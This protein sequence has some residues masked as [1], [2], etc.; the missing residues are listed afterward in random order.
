MPRLESS[1]SSSVIEVQLL[2]GFTVAIDGAAMPAEAWRLKHPRSLFQMLCLKP[3]HQLHR[4]E[5]AGA[6]WPGADAKAAHNRLYHTVHVLRTEFAR[7]GLADSEPVLNF[8][9]GTLQLNPRH[10]FEIDRLAFGKALDRC[11]QVGESVDLASLEAA[12]AFFAGGHAA[13]VEDGSEW[14]TSLH[15][16]LRTGRVWLLERMADRLRDANRSDDAVLA[17]QQLVAIEPANEPAHRALM[18]LF[19]AAGQP[20]KAMLQ[21]ASCKRHLRRELAALPAAETESLREAVVARARGLRTKIA[22]GGTP[23]NSLGRVAL[24]DP[25]IGREAE[26]AELLAW[27]AHV[28]TR[29]VT[30]AAPPGTGKTRLAQA[31]AQRL[32]P[33]RRDGALWVALSELKDANGL[34]ALLCKALGVSAGA[35]AHGAVLRAFLADKELILVLDRFEHLV[36]AAPR[37]SNLIESAPGLQVLVASQRVLRCRFERVFD[38]RQLGR[39]SPTAA[40]ELLQRRA[41]AV[42]M[43]IESAADRDLAAQLCRRLDGNALAIELAAAQLRNG[44]LEELARG[45]GFPL[46][47]AKADSAEPQTRSLRHAIDWSVSRLDAKALDLLVTLGVFERAFDLDDLL[48]VAGA[49]SGDI[50]AR[51]SLQTLL[52]SGL[53]CREARSQGDT[54]A[55]RF[56]MLEFVRRFVREPAHDRPQRAVIE[57]AHAHWFRRRAHEAD[58]LERTGHGVAAYSIFERIEPDL[59]RALDWWAASGDSE[60]YLQTCADA[61]LLQFSH[62]RFEP[63]I[64]RLRSAVDVVAN[65]AAASRHSA[66]CA[67]TLS[68]ALQV[69]N[70]LPGA[71]RAI[72]LAR[73]RACAAAD[74]FLDEKVATQLTALRWM[75]LNPRAAALHIDALMRRFERKYAPSGSPSLFAVA[76]SVR[77]LQGNYA[78]A[79]KFAEASLDAALDRNNLG[80]VRLAQQTLLGA[81]LRK[82]H[83][84]RA[85]EHARECRAI[86]IVGPSGASLMYRQF[87]YFHLHFESAEYEAARESLLHLRHLPVASQ[88]P[89]AREIDIALDFILIETGR[90]GEA[91]NL[92]APVTLTNGHFNPLY[93]QLHAYRLPIQARSGATPEA[94]DSLAAALRLARRTR[95][96][97]WLSWLVEACAH[98]AIDRGQRQA[99]LTLI[100]RAELLQRE[101]SILPS[102]RQLASWSVATARA[103]ALRDA[104]RT[105]TI[106]AFSAGPAW[107]LLAALEEWCRIAVAASGALLVETH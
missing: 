46:D 76:S 41:A 21:Y 60:G 33:K 32:Q 54:S 1:A 70:D 4:D 79:L 40:F 47:M 44:S 8:Q 3:G 83:L 72:R 106:V 91:T 97:L 25:L 75:Q 38:L 42:G 89:C 5:A 39:S 94:L 81:T 69:V 57:A 17:L 86:E 24:D 82:G 95:N 22:E 107:Q 51:G 50:A 15:K 96:P 11:Q 84:A 87:L 67:F 61:C 7:H 102:P 31:L 78:G 6:L 80:D 85:H 49:G 27:F 98:V 14:S 43:R 2:H 74:D 105:N 77:Q 56:H 103:R 45:M 37:L 35:G 9:S 20:D 26:C 104:R 28:D 55:P 52:D 63:A 18:S 68:R 10:R 12:S 66:W 48:S 71:V 64:A 92:L 19:A 36:E 16:E 53:L 101:A 58:A 59:E 99:S 23:F 29:L 93:M 65:T 62:G 73:R 34:E 30:V 88:L 100:A 90:A 13:E